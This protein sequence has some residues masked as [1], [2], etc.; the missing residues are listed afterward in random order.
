M[1]VGA[2]LSAAFAVISVSILTAAGAVHYDD[3]FV[4]VESWLWCTYVVAALCTYLL[5]MAMAILKTTALAL[6]VTCM[7]ILSTSALTLW[8]IDRIRRM[9]KYE[10]EAARQVLLDENSQ[11]NEGDIVE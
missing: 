11:P 1:Q 5:A 3:S 8:F 7:G 4:D 2:A 9:R 10:N 6:G